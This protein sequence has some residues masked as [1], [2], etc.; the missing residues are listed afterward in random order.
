MNKQLQNK[1]DYSIDL[2]RKFEQLALK[3]DERGF[4]VAFSGG[5]DSQVILELTKIAG[6]KY[7]AEM[8]VTTVDP[9]ELMKFVRK[10]Y[11]DVKLNRPKIN[12]YDLIR[13]K[14]S[15]PLI[16]RRFCC[17]YLKELSGANTVTLIGIRA[18]ESVKRAKRNE[19]EISGHKFSGTLDQFNNYRE[20]NVSCVKGKDKILVSPILK[21]TDKDVWDFIH[22]KGLPYCELY[23]EQRR[24]GCM[25]CPMSRPKQKIRE[26]EKYPGVVR[27]FKKAIQYL[28]D[29][30]NYGNTNNLTADE[31]FE[32]WITNKSFKSIN[33]NQLE[34]FK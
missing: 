16:G 13:K 7:H 17:Y 26:L 19:V 1:I 25:F 9:P 27:A 5:K 10:Y 21:W 18:A 31:I 28:I 8:Q 15:L 22:E 2:I 34:L 4:W 24:I 11:P 29:N 14:K 20:T 23:N 12:M 3:Y 33:R 30:N 6:V 32:I